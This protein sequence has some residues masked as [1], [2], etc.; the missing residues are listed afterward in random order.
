MARG[1]VWTLLLIFFIFLTWLGWNEYRKIEAYKQWAVQ[2]EKAK[3]DIVSALGQ[4]Q[5]ALTWGKPTRKGIIDLQTVSLQQVTDITLQVN[6]QAVDPAD[7][8]SSGKHIDL[9]LTV[10]GQT[11]PSRI[12]FTETE[13]AGRWLVHLQKSL[14]ATA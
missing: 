6:G 12:G 9:V 5:D 11:T 13:L 1:L 14:S 3:Y 7:L 8:P 2:F 10:S 4:N